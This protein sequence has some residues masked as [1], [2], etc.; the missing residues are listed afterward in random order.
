MGLGNLCRHVADNTWRPTLSEPCE[1]FM[2]GWWMMHYGAS[3]A[4]RSHGWS[5]A[6]AS[7]L[8]D[9]G[10]LPAKQRKSQTTHQL[11]TCKK[12][13]DGKKTWTG[14]RTALKASQWSPHYP[15][16]ACSATLST[17]IL[18]WNTTPAHYEALYNEA[19]YTHYKRK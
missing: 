3:T 14:V 1:V 10:K 2:T 8:L 19:L 9:A 7:R 12:N 11:A 13:G 16:G 4:K 17:A 6:S 18:H 5:N 15:C